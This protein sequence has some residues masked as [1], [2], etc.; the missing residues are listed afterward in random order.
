MAGTNEIIDG[1]TIRRVGEPIDAWFG[2]KTAGLYQS[3]EEIENWPKNTIYST[4]LKPVIL[5]MLMLLEKA[6][7]IQKIGLFLVNRFHLLIL[8]SISV[9]N[10]NILI[11]SSFQGTLG[12]N[13]YM[14]FDAIG[15]TNGDAQNRLNFG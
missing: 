6:R 4:Q 9:S 11:F 7:S 15:A 5:N 3:A 1:S 10:I 13:G 8:D 2:Y 14:N 12:G